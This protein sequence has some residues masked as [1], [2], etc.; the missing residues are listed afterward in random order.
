LQTWE[1]TAIVDA[2]SD[3]GVAFRQPG[4]QWV[5]FVYS[6]WEHELR[7]RLAAVQGISHDDVEHPILGDLRLIRND[8]VHKRGIATSEWTGRCSTVRWFSVDDEIFI[9]NW[10]V[11][12]VMEAFG[13]TRPRPEQGRRYIEIPPPSR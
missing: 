10:M 1:Q 2:L 8:V 6:M 12:E 7:G 3:R 4:H 9:E 5:V 11:A 13:L